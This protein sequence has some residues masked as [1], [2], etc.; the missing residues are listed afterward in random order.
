MPGADEIRVAAWDALKM[1]KESFMG[2]RA[3]VVGAGSVGCE[4]AQYIREGGAESVAIVELRGKIA[5]DVDNISRLKL[6]NEMAEAE[7]GLYP[8]TVLESVENGMGKLRNVS[9]QSAREV[10][11]DLVVTAVGSL[12]EQSL[13][14]EL[15]ER[16]IAFHMVGDSQTIGKIG[17][18]VRGGFDAAATL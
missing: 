16:G 11:C 13:A 2:K 12:S 8:S 6:M 9:D 15:Y 5:A 18:A 14:Q 3:V 1:P 4:T 17:E 10:P 7:I